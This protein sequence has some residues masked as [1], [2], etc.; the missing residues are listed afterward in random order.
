MKAI[1]TKYAM[2]SGCKVVDGVLSES[3]SEDRPMLV[4]KGSGFVSSDYYHGED[5]QLTKHDAV[6]RVHEMAYKLRKSLD[7]RL[8]NI[9]KSRSKALKQIEEADL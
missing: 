6:V 1:V 2:S 9:E 4:A 5:F 3:S 8:A 7:K